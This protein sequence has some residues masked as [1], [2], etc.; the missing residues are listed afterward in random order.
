MSDAIYKRRFGDRRDGRLIR[1]FPAFNKFMPFIMKTRNDASN[2]FRDSV[3]VTEIDR[4]LRE[5]RAEGYKGMGM[6]H[7]FIAAYIRTIAFR[8]GLNRFVSGQR[9]YTRHDI[10]VIMVVKRAMTDEADETSVKIH[11]SPSDTIYDVYRKINEKVDEIKA[12]ADSDGTEKFAE[13]LTHMP[14][15]FSN[16]ILR[17]LRILDYF[18]CLPASLLEISPFHGS[19]IITDLGSVGIPPVYHHLYNFGNLPLFLAF[20]AKRRVVELDET[21]HPVERKYIDFTATLDERICDGFYHASSFKYIKHYLRNPHLLEV[22]PEK[23]EQD[24]F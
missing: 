22:P 8:P 20:G 24:I 16:F 12:S 23:V 18:G 19:V 4:W 13:T 10:E 7:V 6:L 5:K 21:A 9:V 14:R 11:F 17:I 15:L 2:L 1:S 3:E